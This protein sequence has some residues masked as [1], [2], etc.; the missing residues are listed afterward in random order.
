MHKKILFVYFVLFAASMVA[1]EITFNGKTYPA[2]TN[3]DFISEQY[4]LSG[5]AKV[6]IAKTEKGGLLQLTTAT[7][8]S[9]FTISGTVFLD[10]IDMTIIVCTDKNLHK[11]DG[12]QI[13]SYYFLSPIE[14]SRLQKTEIQSVRYV[15]KGKSNT[16]SSQTGYFTAVNKKAY[17][18]TA[19]DRSK[20]SFDTAAEIKS[21][22]NR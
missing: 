14:M 18:A 15:I 4:A 10:L 16:F 12:N 3:W 9:S 1:Q 2:T 6:Q 20:K 8:N 22:Y 19:Y 11:V 7:T 13:I 17:F 5:I 21:L